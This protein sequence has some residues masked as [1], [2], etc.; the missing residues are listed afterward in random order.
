MP[1]APYCRWHFKTALR[2]GCPAG[3]TLRRAAGSRWDRL[4]GDNPLTHAYTLPS[5]KYFQIALL[6]RFEYPVILYEISFNAAY[7]IGLNANITD[8]LTAS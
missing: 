5:D 2:A 4:D 3:C 6:R 8:R 1:D 7:A